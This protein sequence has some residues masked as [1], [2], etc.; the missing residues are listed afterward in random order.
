MLAQNQ[1]LKNILQYF[2]H[3]KIKVISDFLTA[4]SYQDPKSTSSTRK[5]SF[6]ETFLT[7]YESLKIF[8][9]TVDISGSTNRS[10]GSVNQHC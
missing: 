8:Q 3:M 1:H 2:S 7:Q 9:K 5:I 4:F 10:S 6:N